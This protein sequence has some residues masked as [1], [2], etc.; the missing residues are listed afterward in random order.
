MRINRNNY[1]AYMIDYLDGNLTSAQTDELMLFLDE[2]PDI[3]AEA[4]G[5]DMT[6]NPVDEQSPVYDEKAALKQPVTDDSGT[7][8]EDN[9]ETWFIAFV[10]GNLSN[11]EKSHLHTYLNQNPE[12][13]KELELFK[14]TKLQPEEVTFEN[15]SQLKA[16]AIIPVAGI[17]ASNYEQKMI[18]RVEGDLSL[19]EITDLN[20]FIEQNPGLKQEFEWFKKSKLKED[21]SIAFPDKRH[22]KKY[23]I[24]VT[25]KTLYNFVAA[26]AAIA[27]VIGFSWNSLFPPEHLNMGLASLDRSNIEVKKN[28]NEK[29]IDK[30]SD[31]TKTESNTVNAQSQTQQSRTIKTRREDVSQLNMLASN[32]QSTIQVSNERNIDTDYRVYISDAQLLNRHRR[33]ANDNLM[34]AM[35]DNQGILSVQDIAWNQLENWTGVEKT[36]DFNSNKK[37]IFWTIVDVGLK[38]VNSLTGSDFEL[39]RKVSDEGN[40]KGYSFQSNAFKVSRSR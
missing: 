31:A 29:I 22:L 39:K 2:N 38:G 33:M 26:A 3:K 36:D 21:K 34:M 10:E 32:D 13:Q 4:E 14:A 12:K 28:L 1:E 9:Y 6:V 7:I 35:Q 20:A 5:L 15:K 16:I 11:D 30:S 37:N 25:R 18:A 27:L 23:T 8:T 17:D 40:L 24:G 19:G